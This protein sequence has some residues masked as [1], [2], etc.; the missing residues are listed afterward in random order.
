ML[1]LYSKYLKTENDK[2]WRVEHAQVVS[3]QD[4]KRFKEY[5][6][7]PSIQ[8]THATSDMYWAED[9]LGKDRIHTAYSYQTLLQANGLV[10]LGTDFPI[11]SIDPMLTYYAAVARK[12]L[13]GYPEDSFIAEQKL[14]RKEALFG[15]TIWAALANF[16]EDEKGS[17]EKDKLADFVI[18]DRDLLK[19]PEEQIPDVNVIATYLNGEEVYRK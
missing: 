11:E 6:I 16:E 5:S 18:L 8:P 12:D 13:K 10:A 17:L 4:V 14:S 7:I 15:M 9:R 3:D 2:R 19:V 1:K